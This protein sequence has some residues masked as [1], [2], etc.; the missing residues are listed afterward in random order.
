MWTRLCQ[1]R[2]P[3]RRKKS[4]IIILVLTAEIRRKDA[5]SCDDQSKP[6]SH[7]EFVR[8]D[9]YGYV[10]LCIALEEFLITSVTPNMCGRMFFRN[11]IESV[12]HFFVVINLLSQNDNLIPLYINLLSQNDNLI[13]LY[14]IFILVRPKLAMCPVWNQDGRWASRLL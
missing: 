6:G 3:I 8:I 4:S 12:E 13:P 2:S 7:K 14:F 11:Q 1:T 5:V 9:F 10:F